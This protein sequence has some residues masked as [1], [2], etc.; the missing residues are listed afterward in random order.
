MY[1]S[2]KTELRNRLSTEMLDYLMLVRI[3]GPDVRALSGIMDRVINHFA[4]EK[5]RRVD[6]LST[7]TQLL[8]AAT[9]AQQTPSAKQ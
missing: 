1:R 8:D 5:I 7:V 3:E 6:F 9:A 2:I 4:S